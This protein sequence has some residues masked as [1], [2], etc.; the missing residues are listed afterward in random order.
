MW[1]KPHC[2]RLN[3][4]EASSSFP[5]EEL[6]GLTSQ[7]RHSCVSIPVNIS[8]GCGRSSETDFARFMQIAMGS[9][10][11]VEYLLLLGRDL[12]LLLSQDYEELP[13]EVIEIERMLTSL[14]KTL[15]S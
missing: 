8:E 4:Y 2:L 5:R 9:A 10:S 1:E 12:R 3:V 13:C 11:E 7:I 6:Y 14:I 15:R